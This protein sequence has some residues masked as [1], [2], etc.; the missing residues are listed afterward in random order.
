LL[1]EEINDY[2][3]KDSLEQIRKDPHYQ[4]SVA[5]VRNTPSIMSILVTGQS[6]SRAKSHTSYQIDPL[7]RSIQFNTVEGWVTQLRVS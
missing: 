2:H 5:R 6:F 7:L 4:D 3:K 1:T